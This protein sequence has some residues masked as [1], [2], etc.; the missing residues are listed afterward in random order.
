MLAT[1]GVAVGHILGY[2]VAH[3]S[4]AAREAALGGHAYLPVASSIVMPLGL[5]VALAWGVST[6]RSFGM[7]GRIDVRRLAA[8]Q[9]AVFLVQEVTERV[10]TG[11]G[12]TAVLTER[13]VWIGLVAQILVAW[14]ITRSVDL[15]R[16]AARFVS[17]GRQYLGDR[18]LVTH[19][20][21]SL[22]VFRST[23]TPVAVGLRAPPVAGSIR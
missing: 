1:A 12:A 23:A 20:F 3:P 4:A 17:A 21:V 22:P 13:G 5:L 6:A 7:A 11:D 19:S 18:P 16:R 8:A 2:T 14:A 9:V 15:V 10:V